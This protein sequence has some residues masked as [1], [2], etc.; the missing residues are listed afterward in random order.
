M[1]SS[2][3]RRLVGDMSSL[4]NYATHKFVVSGFG[5]SR[6][7]APEQLLRGRKKRV[8]DLL[9]KHPFADH[10]EREVNVNKNQANLFLV[11]HI[12]EPEAVDL[13]SRLLL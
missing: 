8:V 5:S 1:S 7:Q 12:P 13:F 9:S 3:S 2:S 6:W 4:G 10:L 11:E